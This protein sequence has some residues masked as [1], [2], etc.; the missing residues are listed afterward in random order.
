MSY[1][2]L[3]GLCIA[4]G[5]S[6]DPSLVRPAREVLHGLSWMKLTPQSFTIYFLCIFEFLPVMACDVLYITGVVYQ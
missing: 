5:V 4:L 2:S 6:W 3:T 1:F